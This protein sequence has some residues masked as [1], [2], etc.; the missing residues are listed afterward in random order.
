MLR[1][2]QGQR[3][4][5]QPPQP[6]Y[7]NPGG[8]AQGRMGQNHL[9]EWK[10]KGMDTPVSIMLKPGWARLN[11]IWGRGV[12]GSP[13]VENLDDEELLLL[14]ETTLKLVEERSKLNGSNNDNQRSF[15]KEKLCHIED[16]LKLR[17]LWDDG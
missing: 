11:F 2:S 9:A 1:I 3:G 8:A 5:V 6:G 14:H 13:N 7:P 17:S 15:L 4:N 10:K 16:E 12:M